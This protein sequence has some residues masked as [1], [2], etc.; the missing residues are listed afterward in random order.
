M[1]FFIMA[2]AFV[3]GGFLPVQ[4]AVNARLETTWAHHPVLTALVSFVVG[5]VA[6]G[7]YVLIARVPLP[8]LSSQTAA[9]QWTGGL[10][11]AFYVAAMAVVLPREGAAATVAAVLAGQVLV[12]LAIDKF[13]LLG[14][15]ARELTWQRILGALLIFGGMLLVK[16]F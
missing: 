6:L 8:P 9:W 7:A 14:V 10:V 5:T 16:R 15:M 1:D 4:M 3:A 2:L 11:G 12:S 13:A